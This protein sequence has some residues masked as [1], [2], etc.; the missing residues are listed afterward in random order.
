MAATNVYPCNG[1]LYNTPQFW[2]LSLTS[3]RWQQISGLGLYGRNI[4]P[5]VD[6]LRL[7]PLDGVSGIAQP[8]EGFGGIPKSL[9]I[10][11]SGG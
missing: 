7:G 6:G 5:E 10:E 2:R 4:L 11:Y 1:G 9:L 3:P 8:Y